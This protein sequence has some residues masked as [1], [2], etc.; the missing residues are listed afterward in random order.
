MRKWIAII[1][2]MICILLMVGC[3]GK[4]MSERGENVPEVAGSDEDESIENAPEVAGNDENE[5]ME[6]EQWDMI[7]MVMVNGELY[8]DT[9]HESTVEARCGVMDGQ[10]DSTVDSTE[11]PSEDNQSNFGAGYGYQYGP[12]EGTIEIYMNDKWWVFTTGDVRQE[13]QFPTEENDE[14]PEENGELPEE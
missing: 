4:D 1:L 2:M 5:T 11:K 9:G 13:I 10:I 6:E 7:P 14:L 8:L 12:T 3:A